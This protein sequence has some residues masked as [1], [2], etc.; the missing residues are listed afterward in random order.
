M[1]AVR[2]HEFG[3]P[4]VLRAEDVPDPRP[5]PG[6]ALIR[7]RA[8]A[9]NHVELDIRAGVSRLDI[10]LPATL[11]AEF[12]GELV[13]VDGPAPEG[14]DPGARVTAVRFLCCG[15]CVYCATGRDNLCLQREMLGV[16]R[17]GGDAEY[18]C[19]PSTSLLVL[20]DHLPYETAAAAQVGFSIAWHVLL[21]R[22]ELRAG[23]SVLVHAAGS[24]VGSA[25]LQ[26]ARFAGARVIA[27]AASEEKRRR[28]AAFADETVD[29]TAPGWHERVLELTS[30]LGV[31]V[32]LS[33]VGGEEFLGS[34]RAVRPDGAVVVMGA[35]AGEV[36]PLDL[37]ALFRRQVRVLGSSRATQNEVRTAMAYVCAGRFVPAVHAT[38]PLEDLAAA[39][40]LLEDRAVY[41]KVVCL[42]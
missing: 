19:V 38:L 21:T 7:V 40:R 15:R 30:G 6:E 22:A 35:H 3:G 10:P 20:P 26:V 33:H 23:Q 25:A 2:I 13:S 8:V 41:G 9:V 12:A 27:T 16:T 11:G 34:L 32:V 29:Y 37:V 36:V 42:A 39:H 31:D 14:A 1:R 24:G 18:V 5:G 28:A 17:P 4:D